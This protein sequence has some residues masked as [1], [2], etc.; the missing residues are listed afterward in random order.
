MQSQIFIS[1]RKCYQNLIIFQANFEI[2]SL[3]NMQKFLLYQYARAVNILQ[4]VESLDTDFEL[5]RGDFIF[6]HDIEIELIMT[7][8]GLDQG[9][10]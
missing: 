1:Y 3:A 9:R 7:V 6:R 5:E 4:R 10:V 2:F 8:T